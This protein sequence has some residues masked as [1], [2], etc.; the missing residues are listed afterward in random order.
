M[1]QHCNYAIDFSD[2]DLILLVSE[3]QI[4]TRPKEKGSGVCY[5]FLIGRISRLTYC[6]Q[7]DQYIIRLLRVRVCVKVVIIMLIPGHA[8]QMA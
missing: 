4:Q 8:T 2:P 1:G 5:G 6:S 7:P 3:L